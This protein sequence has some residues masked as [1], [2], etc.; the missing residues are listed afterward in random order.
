MTVEDFEHFRSLLSERK[1]LLSEYLDRLDSSHASEAS[2]VRGLLSEIDQ[3]L[4]RVGERTFG[5]CAHCD[6]EVEYERLEVQPIRQVCL[7]CITPEEQAI[8]EEE[9]A[10]ASKIHRALLPQKVEAIAGYEFAVKSIAARTVGGDYFDFIRQSNGGVKV[11]IADSMG[12]GIPGSL[13][14]SNFQGA[15]RVLAS[16]IAT[17]GYLASKLNQWLCRNVPLTKFISMVCVC[18]AE[19]SNQLR[20]VNAGH[21]APLVIRTGGGIER[22][23]STGGVLGVHE[24]FEYSEGTVELASG[25]TLLLYTDGVSEAT[26]ASDVQFEESGLVPFCGAHQSGSPREFIDNLVKEISRF[27]GRSE[28][29]DDL[30]VIALRRV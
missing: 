28:F 14:M 26:G 30:T 18:L 11:I 6:G 15:L 1:D 8:L 4:D 19:G 23:E 13:L 24:D 16:E 5:C 7:G 12:K 17:P 21:P 25:E 22:L 2:K 29:A 20:Y 9:L 27:T 3:A 10:F